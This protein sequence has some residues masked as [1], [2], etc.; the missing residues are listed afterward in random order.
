[1]EP[2]AV[3]LRVADVETQREF[4]ERAI[5]LRP[6]DSADGVT[7]LGSDGTPR[8]RAAQ[9]AAGDAFELV[10]HDGRVAARAE[11]VRLTEQG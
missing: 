2:E 1:M 11:G 9:F 4:Y 5:G 8:G 7:R 10:L 6:I 3:R